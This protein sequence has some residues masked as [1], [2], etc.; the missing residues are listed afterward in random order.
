MHTNTV[1]SEFV[2]VNS[3]Q[4]RIH[5]HR[6]ILCGTNSSVSWPG[7]VS[8]LVTGRAGSGAGAGSWGTTATATST[9]SSRSSSRRRRAPMSVKDEWSDSEESG[10]LGRKHAGEVS[11]KGPY[12]PVKMLPLRISQNWEKTKRLQGRFVTDLPRP[13]SMRSISIAARP[14]NSF[15]VCSSLVA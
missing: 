3:R 13:S 5:K 9:A 12:D 10:H 1:F 7:S 6:I 15:M 2:K 11:V 14:R 8:A 4:K